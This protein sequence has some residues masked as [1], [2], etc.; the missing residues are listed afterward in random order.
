MVLDGGT[1]VGTDN[2]QE[3]YLCVW[4]VWEDWEGPTWSRK[5][6]YVCRTERTGEGTDLMLEGCLCV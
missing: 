3:R 2:E 1:G 6:I 4:G 5:G